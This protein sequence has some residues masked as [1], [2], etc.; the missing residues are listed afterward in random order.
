MQELLSNEQCV[1]NAF[2]SWMQEVSSSS[3]LSPGA[4]I[5]C[6]AQIRI[7]NLLTGGNSCQGLALK[8]VRGKKPNRA[9]TGEYVLLRRKLCGRWTLSK[10][11]RNSLSRNRGSGCE[12]WA[13]VELAVMNSLETATVAWNSDL[14]LS[15]L[16]PKLIDSSPWHC[17]WTAA[18]FAGTAEISQLA[19]LIR[20]QVCL[21]PDKQKT[22]FLTPAPTREW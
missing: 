22:L 21:S 15:G 6:R 19:L 9:E 13:R 1:M 18:L 14:H 3:R 16:C 11:H 7:P 4:S 8:S 20:Q 17:G 5:W 12:K 2:V 10:R